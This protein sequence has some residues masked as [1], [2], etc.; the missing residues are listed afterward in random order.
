MFFICWCLSD[1]LTWRKHCHSAQI[2]QCLLLIL[3]GSTCADLSP[4]QLTDSWT[5]YNQPLFI[6]F[7]KNEWFSTWCF[8]KEDVSF[9]LK[10]FQCTIMHYPKLDRFSSN[11]I[12]NANL[13][14]STSKIWYL[15]HK[16]CNSISANYNFMLRFSAS[17]FLC[18]KTT[19]ALSRSCRKISILLFM[20]QH[21]S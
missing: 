20:Y 12:L 17:L 14:R 19:H 18:Y 3:A 15:E 5:S 10:L 2:T 13:L 16:G 9:L 21:L 11:S 4:P 6:L 7:I 8:R 1:M